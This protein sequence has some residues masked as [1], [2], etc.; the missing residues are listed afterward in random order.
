MKY[1]KWK[2][3]A[4]II[5]FIA[6]GFQL[7]SFLFVP[8][9]DS[10]VWFSCGLPYGVNAK[11]LLQWYAGICAIFLYTSA[12]IERETADNKLNQLLRYKTR[13]HFFFRIL[14]K[15]IGRT[16]LL[17]IVLIIITGCIRWK[18]EFYDK[19]LLTILDFRN[20]IIMFIAMIVLATTQLVLEMFL[21]HLYAFGLINI[22]TLI[23]LGLGNSEKIKLLKV[24]MLPNL[25]M[26]YRVEQS[27]QISAVVM[28]V[29]IE[30]FMI[31]LYAKLSKNK[32]ICGVIT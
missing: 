9:N 6:M 4:L 11:Q 27:K 16:C 20:I 1:N 7:E 17:L 14:F 24:F 10:F 25:L 28:I 30:I 23:G 8:G 2:Q 12:T 32:N 5:F 18:F 31:L 15:H 3:F 26:G 13:K 21:P 22:Y 19:N 29:A